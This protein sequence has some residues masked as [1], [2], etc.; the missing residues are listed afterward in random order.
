MNETGWAID[1]DRDD[2]ARATLVA[3]A[4]TPLEAGQVR[5]HIDSYAMTANNITY[6]V[7][8]KPAGLFGND[9]GYWDFFAERDAPGR[10]PVWGFATVTESAAEGIAA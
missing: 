1:I 3:D 5:V 9:Q 7:F 2:I 6:A 10:L 8:G 4:A